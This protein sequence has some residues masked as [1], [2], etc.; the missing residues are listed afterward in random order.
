MSLQQEESYDGVEHPVRRRRQVEGRT[1]RQ[2]LRDGDAPAKV[3]A[4]GL[5]LVRNGRRDEV[6]SPRVRVLR[7]R[8]EREGGGAGQADQPRAVAAS[9]LERYAARWRLKLA[10]IEHR[11]AELGLSEDDPDGEEY[12]LLF[13]LG[14][15][16]RRQYKATHPSLE[17]ILSHRAAIAHMR[18][19]IPR[20]LLD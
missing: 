4:V 19:G 13:E 17:M 9:D 18:R 5:G 1:R 2:G 11:L 8:R 16:R 7:A 20:I 15:A 6:R 14:C 10:C 12:H 3:A